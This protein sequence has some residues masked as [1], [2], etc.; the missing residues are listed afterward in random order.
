MTLSMSPRRFANLS[1][2]RAAQHLTQYADYLASHD[3]LAPILSSN[4][5]VESKFSACQN[6]LFQHWMT[7]R[8]VEVNQRIQRKP[9][10]ANTKTKK[11]KAPTHRYMVKVFDADGEQLDV[12]HI[13]LGEGGS[14]EKV[15]KPMEFGADDYASAERAADRRLFQREDA[16]YA[17]VN[18]TLGE[19]I[20]TRIDRGD[21]VA[22]I[23]AKPRHAVMKPGKKTASLHWAPKSR[24]SRSSTRW[25]IAR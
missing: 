22:R 17:E 25:F 7:T 9:S 2:A 24:A 14:I 18:N 15:I 23:L 6:A 11:A 12:A 19:I 5:A 16:S 20:T 13:K 10:K 1:R 21:A 4:S 8:S 3:F